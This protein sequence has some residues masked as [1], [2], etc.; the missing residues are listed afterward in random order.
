M[1]NM[2]LHDSNKDALLGAASK[3]LGQSPEAIKRALDTGDVDELKKN[4]DPK[5]AA[6]LNSILSDPKKLEEI[7][8]NKQLMQLLGMFSKK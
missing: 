6:Q 4:L 7:L 3:K 1:K 2:N 8:Q 5:T